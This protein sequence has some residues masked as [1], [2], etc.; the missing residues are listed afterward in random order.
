MGRTFGDQRGQLLQEVLDEVGI[1][2]GGDGEVFATYVVK[3]F[4]SGKIKAKDA[5][6]CS[7]VYLM[8]EIFKH[9]PALILSLGKT[10][11]VAVMKDATPLSKTH[12]KMF[13]HTFEFEGKE[14][15]TKVMPIEHPYAILSEPTKLDPWMADIRRAKTVLY[16]EGDPYWHDDKLER[17]DFRVIDSVSRF[18]EVARELTSEAKGRYMTLDVEASGLDDVMMKPDFKVFTLQFG[19]ADMENKAAND[20]LPVYIL[21]LQSAHFPVCRDPRWLPKVTG[22]LNHFLDLR[23]FQLVAHNGKYDLKALRRIGVYSF[24]AWDTMMLW[25]NAHGESPMSLKEIAY[26]VT[27]LGGYEKKM[28]AYF[29][30]HGTY[31]APPEILVPYGGLDVVVT[32]H[33][34]FEMDNTIMKENRR[35]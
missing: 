32:R 13:D 17:F 29:E 9:K 27:D 5:R 7:D 10:A 14:F 2:T 23:Y 24:L 18:K 8:K 34:M 25:S 26:Q 28:E 22:M 21:P 1:Q 20:D 30:E 12:G 16:S 19:I 15:S 11:Q 31:D 6:T 3:C 33:T 4:P 35:I